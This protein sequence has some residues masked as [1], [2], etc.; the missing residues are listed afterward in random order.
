MTQG[1]GGVAFGTRYTTGRRLF[2]RPFIAEGQ[3]FLF[4]HGQDLP[5]GVKGLV[6]K[7]GHRRHLDRL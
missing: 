3:L 7:F 5:Q 2:G 6:G 4:F 1:S